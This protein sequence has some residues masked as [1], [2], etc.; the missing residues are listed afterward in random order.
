M[1]I[2]LNK[3]KGESSRRSKQVAR[4]VRDHAAAASHAIALLPPRVPG[5]AI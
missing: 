3:C 1:F 2:H 5:L 4:I